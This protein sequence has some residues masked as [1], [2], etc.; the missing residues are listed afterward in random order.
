LDLN[1]ENGNIVVPFEPTIRFAT[2][3]L[4]GYGA[5]RGVIVINYSPEELLERFKQFFSNMNGEVV[6]LNPEGYWLMGSD[7]EKLWGFMFDSPNTFAKEY[8]N[9]WQQMNRNDSGNISGDDG[10]YIYQK[11]YLFSLDNIGS[12]EN[13]EKERNGQHGEP[14]WILVSMVSNDL[15]RQLSTSRTVITISAYVSLF[16]LSG[17]ISYFFSKV[18]SQRQ[19]AYQQ[20]EEH[21]VTDALTGISN[22]RELMIS[23]DREVQR[24]KRFNRQLCVM[25]L[26]LDHFK[27]VNDTYGHQ[28]GDHILKHFSTICKSS[29]R[30]QDLLA[31][32]GGEEFV[33]TMPETSIDGA[34][35]LAERIC[36]NV[37]KQPYRNNGDEIPVTVS[38]GVTAFLQTD[39]DY[40]QMLERADYALYQAK[41][42]GRDRCEVIQE[43]RDSPIDTDRHKT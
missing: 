7:S 25:M 26:D 39:R 1:I 40:A 34:T 10:M 38:I 14:H 23:G 27:R 20:L 35:E 21:A 28:I 24:A 16:F 12:P 22:R 13:I 18:A 6:M 15:I 42:Q 30:E 31:R 43:D 5:K 4:D 2:P 17:F 3:I 32:F 29:I 36:K 11:A 37:R 9:I 41:N 33:V 8:P 19:L